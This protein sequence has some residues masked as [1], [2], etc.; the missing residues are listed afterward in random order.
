M[1]EKT[2]ESPLTTRKSNPAAAAAAKSLQSC[3]TLH[4]PWT[5]DRQAPVFLGFPRQ[6][7][8]SGLP[9]RSPGDLSNPG[10]QPGSSALAGRFFTTRATREAT[11][12]YIYIYIDIDIDIDIH[13]YIIFNANGST[14]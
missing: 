7:Y 11:C 8:W 9:F 10:I 13:E 6:E 1:L 14:L 5:V 12:I 4:D 3:L 2:L